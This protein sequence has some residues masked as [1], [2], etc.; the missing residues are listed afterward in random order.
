M[1]TILNKALIVIAAILAVFAIAGC[2]EGSGMT[3]LTKN[4]PPGS[5]EL[6][7][8]LV[9]LNR[10]RRGAGLKEFRYQKELEEAA[11]NHARYLDDV[12]SHYGVELGHEEPTEYESTYRTGQWG[13]ERAHSAGYTGDWAGNDIA[14]YDNTMTAHVQGLLTAIYHR[15]FILD[16]EMDE[17]GLY[18]SHG[19]PCRNTGMINFGKR[20]STRKLNAQVASDII[21]Y[22][23][24]GQ[25]G[26]ETL[27][28]GG[29]IPDPLQGTDLESTGNPITIL[30][31]GEK[32]THVSVTSFSLQDA[33]GSAVAIALSLNADNDPADRLTD[34]Q[35]AFFPRQELHAGETYTARI[36]YTADGSPGSK[37]W[38]FTTQD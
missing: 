7:E 22:P 26:V 29:E 37:E 13:T 21:L 14:L 10:V 31:N 17:I 4:D 30:F 9:F 38:T 15:W 33:R 25:K 2:S 5:D 1:T 6:R 12:C 11:E 16:P 23:Y 28:D 36:H 27:F 24:D 35:F 3:S 19:L 34:H 8:G 20:E 18:S 32:I